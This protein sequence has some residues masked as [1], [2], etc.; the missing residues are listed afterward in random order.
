MRITNTLA[1]LFS[2]LMFFATGI[3]ILY[4]SFTNKLIMQNTYQLTVNIYVAQT[5]KDKSLG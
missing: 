3:V 4:L 2:G 1:N 5:T